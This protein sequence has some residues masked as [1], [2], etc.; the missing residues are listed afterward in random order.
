M[1]SF[2]F[3]AAFGGF[4]PVGA[5]PTHTCKSSVSGQVLNGVLIA[6]LFLTGLSALPCVTNHA[7]P[8]QAN[9]EYQVIK[10]VYTDKH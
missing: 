5:A 9:G 8:L 2:L 6:Y 7:E 3:N 10:Q 1:D 4:L